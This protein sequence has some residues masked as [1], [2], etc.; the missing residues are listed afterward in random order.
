MASALALLQGLGQKVRGKEHNECRTL[1]INV[2]APVNVDI[3][4]NDITME[5]STGLLTKKK[6]TILT[7]VSG[8]FKSGQLTAIMGPSGAGKTTLLNA[9]TG[10]S[11]EGVKGKIRAG[12]SI[13]ELGRN[14]KYQ[15]L[16][17]YRKKSCYILQDDRLNPLFTVGELMKFAADLKLGN[18]LN[19][20]L[21][22]SVINDV[23][24]TLGLTGTE[25]TRC[26][27][28][29]GGQR[30]R[31]S[32]AVELIDNP[33]VIFLDE[34]TTG[35]DSTTSAHCMKMLKELALSGR[36]IVFT[37][38]QPPA[39]LYKM[40][41]QVYI[42][43]EGKCIYDGPSEDTVPYLASLGLQCPKYHNPADY[44]L[45]IANGEYGK[46]NEFLAAKIC[47]HH[48]FDEKPFIES[49]KMPP[50][51]SCG[52]L[53]IV[54]NNPPELYKFNV[55]FKRCLIQLYRDWTVTHLKI[56]LHIALGILMGIFY[57]YMGNDASKTF[58]NLGYLIISASYLCYTS[59]MPG[60]LKFPDELPVLKKESFNNWYNLRTYYAATLVTSIPL[61]IS[62]SIVYSAPSYLLSGQPTELWRF[63]MFVLVLA[64][65]TLLADAIGNL[66]GTCVQAINGTFFGAITTCAMIVFAG[67]LVLTSH[68]SPLMQYLSFISFLKYVFEALALSVYAYNR[69]PLDCPES[70]LYCHMKLK[71]ILV[72]LI[73]TKSAMTDVSYYELLGVAKGASTQ[74]IKQAY[75]K[76]AVKL[77]PDKNSDKGE[78]KKFLEITEAYETLKD[79][80]KRHKYDLY[81]SQQSYTR[82]YDYHSQSEYNDLYFNG[83]YHEDP[84]VKTLSADGF[85]S[86]L[87]E[88]LCFINFYSPFC[89][90][91][92]NLAKHWKNLAKVYERIINVGA[93]NCKYY[94]S[95][96]YN[97]MRIGSYPTLL[98]YPNGKTGNYLRYNGAHTFD[99]LEDFIIKFVRSRVHVGTITQVLNTDKPILY[100]LNE[101]N[102][103]KNAI[104]RIAYHLNGLATV[105]IAENIRQRISNNPETVIV[106]K[107]NKNHKEI[108]SM[109][110]KEII[111]EVVEMLPKI[112]EI[113]L[114]TLQKIRNNLRNGHYTPWVLYFTTQE[115]DNILLLHQMQMALPEMNFGVLDCSALEE[116]CRSLQ[117]E[118]AAGWALLKAG[119][120]FQ[121]VRGAAPAALRR[122]AHARA[123]H[124][125]S[126]SELQRVL[127]A[128]MGIWVLL[129][130]P[131]EVSWEHLEEPFTQA[132]FE[133]LD[134]GISFGIMSCTSTT[135][136]YCREV[137]QDEPVILVQNGTNRFRYVGD[138]NKDEIIEFIELLIETSDMELSAQEA[139]TLE[140]G[141]A[142]GAGRA[143]RVCAC[144]LLPARCGPACDRIRHEWRLV[145]KRL[146]PLDYVKVGIIDCGV[147]QLSI[148]NIIR[149]PVAKVYPLDPNSHINTIS[150]QHQT[151]APYILDWAL[152]Y[153]Y[154]KVAKL[155]WQSF[156][157][158]VIAEELYPS[159]TKKPWLIYFH[160]PRC[161]HC[162]VMYPDFVIAAFHLENS[163]QFGKVNCIT[164]RNICQHEHIQ[165]YPTIK[166]YLNRD[167]HRATRVVTFQPKD[168]ARLIEEIKPHLTRY[169]EIP[170]INNIEIKSHINFRDEL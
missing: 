155:N 26:C 113:G 149:S 156:T 18:C 152:D 45:E 106:F 93:V 17:E 95:F 2:P 87:G 31:L 77:H 13:C 14:E 123:L 8:H 121:R 65:V 89:P 78:Q 49:P 44:I 98:F 7:N 114:K 34:P 40:F 134:S 64:N 91:C 102:I 162:Y 146:R 111:Q 131:Y 165:S 24:E 112:E 150:L 67:F 43:A 70:E 36:T 56:L 100:V 90:P 47:S 161:Y 27:N 82:K 86:Y 84:F 15:D 105:V 147:L 115:D 74:E 168:Y 96:C 107:Y 169:N 167:Q 55:L 120:A 124:S 73:L 25:N 28:L 126:V 39:S 88:G 157:K 163:L 110:E 83:L 164:E 140:G 109:D 42:L 9:L 52:K 141:G 51:F 21:K 159:S 139:R 160:S 50:K 6:K 59:M 118:R 99:A 30:K 16:K 3:G 22:D 151:Q 108:S 154:D 75:K 133:L 128:E 12:D 29:S 71:F 119:G 38:H 35:L 60:V 53:T 46:F 61:Q 116:L 20:K 142:G 19:A 145:A 37:I 4:F 92:Q 137:A 158:N 72:L 153:I 170:G 62:F 85:Y 54:V 23:L 166:L 41:D 5:V 63:A 97:N 132:S 127:A 11:V 48:Y 130:A 66:I 57:Q 138:S 58:S 76:L 129:I 136:K 32:I 10:F 80:Q 148:C 94:N 33:P 79:P 1:Q 69:A 104:L 101:D 122:A 135:D 144:A 143:G 81:G 117:W 68:M 125:L 103:G